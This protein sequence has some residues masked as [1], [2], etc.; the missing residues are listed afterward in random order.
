MARKI[1]V[2]FGVVFFMALILFTGM[3]FMT[4][5]TEVYSQG[6]IKLEIEKPAFFTLAQPDADGKRSIALFTLPLGSYTLTERKLS[7][8]TTVVFEQL[9]NTSWLPFVVSLN[10]TGIESADVQSWNPEPVMRTTDPEYGN[11]PTTNPFGI[12]AMDSIQILQGNIYVSRDLTLGNGVPVNEL[13]HE[14]VDFTIE[15][16]KLLKNFWLAPKYQ[17]DSWF[18]LSPEPFFSTP[19]DEEAWISHSAENP[20][21]RLNWL[22]P[23]GSMVKIALTDDLR[24]EMAYSTAAEKNTSSIAETWQDNSPAVYFESILLNAE[25]AKQP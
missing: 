12:I 20:R 16:G 19:Q 4:N 17:A 22:T 1:I 5:T 7:N 10:T 9:E 18:M 2:L 15:E 11:D 21:D 23:D 6:G 8:G 13:R 25:Y 24:T 14:I 3:M